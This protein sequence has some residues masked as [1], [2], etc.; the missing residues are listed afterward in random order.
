M[1]HAGCEQNFCV[2]Q[3]AAQAQNAGLFAGPGYF[4]DAACDVLAQGPY[5][6]LGK[7]FLCG[8]GVK[9]LMVGQFPGEDFVS[10][11][12]VYCID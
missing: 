9:L 11:I 2:A 7:K 12:T 6:G 4:L 8:A 5:R 3:P 1:S 10:Q